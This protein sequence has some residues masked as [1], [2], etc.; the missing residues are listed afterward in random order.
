MLGSRLLSIHLR[1]WVLGLDC[2]SCMFGSNLTYDW[3]HRVG[4]LVLYV[5][6]QAVSIYLRVRVLELEVVVLYVWIW[7]AFDL[8]QC[9]SIGDSGVCFVCL[10]LGYFWSTLGLVFQG[11]G[12][13]SCMFGSRSRS[14]YLRVKVF[15][16]TLCV[17]YVW[18]RLLSV[19]LRVKVFE[20]G[21]LV[22][23]V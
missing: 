20:L 23:Y 7:V 3:G 19:Y 10:D 18:V 16:V 17:L 9:Q 4:A 1:V 5:W 21:V 2:L 6:T 22:L 8:P 11:Q 15:R 14:I 12:C 13:L